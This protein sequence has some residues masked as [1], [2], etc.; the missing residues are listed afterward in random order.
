MSLAKEFLGKLGKTKVT[1]MRETKGTGAPEYEDPLKSFMA[2]RPKKV[3]I[4]VQVPKKR[5]RSFKP[6]QIVASTE[7]AKRAPRKATK[8]Y[9][10]TIAL[11]DVEVDVYYPP[12]HYSHFLLMKSKGDSER[13][14]YKKYDRKKKVF[15]TTEVKD[16]SGDIASKLVK[17]GLF[18][19]MS[20]VP[21][22]VRDEKFP[23]LAFDENDKQYH[24]KLKEKER[25]KL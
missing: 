14:F 23:N 9:L 20:D 6:P 13:I 7:T 17:S 11:P 10:E 5:D 16:F 22:N 2:S 4:P 25:S 24:R 15:E 19:Y 12:P 8:F 21:A 18:V 3:P 1:D